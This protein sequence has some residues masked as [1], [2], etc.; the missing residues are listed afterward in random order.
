MLMT[1]VW[2]SMGVRDFG[3]SL[4][5]K[6]REGKRRDRPC[7][8][9]LRLNRTSH[10]ATGMGQYSG[11][12]RAVL[13]GGH[14]FKLQAG[15]GTASGKPKRDAGP[16]SGRGKEDERR[17]A[18]T[19]SRTHSCVLETVNGASGGS[20]ATLYVRC[21]SYWASCFRTSFFPPW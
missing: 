13:S 15:P 16:S 7:I 14:Q 2:G 17:A 18:Q 12:T 6:G 21:V 8:W 1:W 4:W 3:R 5:A 9:G 19:R 20:V 10:P 11:S